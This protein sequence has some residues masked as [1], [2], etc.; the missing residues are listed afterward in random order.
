V[1]SGFYKGITFAE[2]RPVQADA[3]GRVQVEAPT[4]G[5]GL[6]IGIPAVG[7]FTGQD[8]SYSLSY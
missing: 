3:T 6:Q 2:L 1:L 4:Y 5:Q 8:A 7:D